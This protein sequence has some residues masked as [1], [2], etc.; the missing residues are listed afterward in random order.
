MLLTFN[1]TFGCQIVSRRVNCATMRLTR[2]P[3]L[4]WTAHTAKRSVQNT[5][6]CFGI[7]LGSQG[8]YV[9]GLRKDELQGLAEQ[10]NAGLDG[11]DKALGG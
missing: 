1:K 3:G 2:N 10:L 6:F 9:C 5:A 8:R 7:Q 4:V 11:M